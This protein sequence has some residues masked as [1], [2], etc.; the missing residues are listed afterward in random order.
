MYVVS[1]RN[2]KDINMYNVSNYAWNITI[3]GSH[4]EPPLENLYLENKIELEGLSG[5]NYF[6]I[7]FMNYGLLSMKNKK[8]HKLNVSYK[9]SQ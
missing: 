8:G 9:L 3:Q 4:N 2:K 5:R 7:Y 1:M 6:Q